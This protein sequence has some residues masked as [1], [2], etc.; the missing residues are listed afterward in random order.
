MTIGIT[1]FSDLTL[2]SEALCGS[3]RGIL[4]T[5]H[6]FCKQFLNDGSEVLV[7]EKRKGH[8]G[9]TV[10]PEDMVMYFKLPVVKPNV[11]VP[12]IEVFLKDR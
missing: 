12:V 9:D 5:C 3:L 7:T 1:K 8:H 4:C 6:D 2:L 11:T 10:R